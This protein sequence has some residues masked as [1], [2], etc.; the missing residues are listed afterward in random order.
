MNSVMMALGWV[1]VFLCIGMFL[2]SKI[3]FLGKIM[4]PSSVLAGI[5]GFLFMNCGINA[6]TD[7][8]TYTELVNQIFVISFISIGL[9]AEGDRNKGKDHVVR[10]SFRMGIIWCLLYA[11]T[12]LI[13]GLLAGC[14]SGSFGMDA[15]YGTLIPFGF[16]QGPGQAVTFGLLYESYGF[17]DAAGVSLTFAVTG[18]MAAFLIGVPLARKMVTS[19]KAK[20]CS[21]ITASTMKGYP[22]KEEQEEIKM[23]ETTHA[24]NL[25]MLSFHLAL[26][27]VCYCAA[28]AIGRLFSL[29]PG[30]FGESMSNLLFMNGLFAAYLVRFIMKK[31][32][33][34]YLQD[35]TVQKKI[36]GWT[37]DFLV[38]GSFM[39]VQLSVIVK[40]IVPILAVCAVATAITFLVCVYYGRK[41]E[42][43]GREERILGLFG[44]CTGTVPSGIALVRI[45]DP[46]MKTRTTEEL[47]L[48]NMF[49]LFSTP[50]YFVLLAA[51]SGA[52]SI[53]LTYGLLAVMV[54]IYFG[55][56]AA[57]SKIRAR[58]E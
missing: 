32:K 52:I 36:T 20:N 13:G 3:P 10:H 25:E 39:A 49:M 11:A 35:M 53:W 31:L 6:G 41:S 26:I 18:F 24:S 38:V 55:I 19:G 9:T 40:W 58:K 21:G 33:I 27:G 2:R 15:L 5:L 48:M 50:V 4:V 42:E 8:A 22:P 30:F 56:F 46:D 29:I 14:M 57:D 1:G 16:A 34:T 45:I 23:K 51:A 12:P 37:S 54:I 47:G 28:I 17:A 7:A 43:N 44:T